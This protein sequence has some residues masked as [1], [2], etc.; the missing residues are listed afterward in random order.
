MFDYPTT[1]LELRDQFAD[2]ASM[3][4]ILGQAAQPGQHVKAM[5]HRHV[6]SSSM[7]AGSG[8]L[9]RSV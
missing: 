4:A 2:E 5:L 6:Q 1:V 9:L 7:T 3:S 8:N